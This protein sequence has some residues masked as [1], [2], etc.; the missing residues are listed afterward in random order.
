MKTMKRNTLLCA[1]A[2]GIVVA[3]A[4]YCPD[5]Y[6]AETI[7]VSDGVEE[8]Q[9]Q[10]ALRD[11]FDDNKTAWLW[12]P[13]SEDPN[14]AAVLEV[15]KRLELRTS[16]EAVDAFAAYMGNMWRLDTR[17]DFAMRVDFHYDLFT[18]EEE[19]WIGIGL[20]PN[21]DD[22]RHQ[23][24]EFGAGCVNRFRSF[25]YEQAEGWSARTG[26]SERFSDSG[27]LYFSYDSRNDILYMSPAGYGPDM[28][29][30]VCTDLIRGAWESLPIYVY[31]GGRS[32]NLNITSGHAHLDNITIEAGQIIEAALRPVYRFWSRTNK[33]YFYTISESEK[34]RLVTEQANVWK[35]EGAAF[36]GFPSGADPNSRPV[37]RFWSD[38]TMSYFYTINDSETST[39]ANDFPFT[40]TYEGVAFYAYHGGMQPAWARPVYRFLSSDGAYL[41]TMSETEADKLRKLPN[42]WS[43]EGV[44]WY[45]VP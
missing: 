13:Y 37:H 28:A 26:Y 8:E 30:G 43:D 14:H 35:Y 15:N 7:V 33:S 4:A 6:A 18:H 42:T 16:A 1:L 32:A 19:G 36:R 12:R 27:T 40:W 2:V 34:D 39:L 29:W 17:Y 38:K 10:I 22:S 24:V 25:S 21:E 41:Y 3:A 5:A 45:A 31:L 9:P 20:T 23:K 11:S 44:A